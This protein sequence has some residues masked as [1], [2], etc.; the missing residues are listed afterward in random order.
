MKEN[1]RREKI[2][3]TIFVLMFLWSFCI[4]VPRIS[5]MHCLSAIW[6]RMEHPEEV[7]QTGR[8]R[9]EKSEK[10]EELAADAVDLN[11]QI[12]CLLG[13]TEAAAGQ[14]RL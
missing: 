10:E 1:E 11:I 6:H 4:E 14:A 7:G 12:N 3:K 5:A 9:Y 2:G 8:T 13:R